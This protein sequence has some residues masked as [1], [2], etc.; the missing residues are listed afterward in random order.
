MKI[1]IVI[2]AFN[3]EKLLASTLQSLDSALASLQ[4]SGWETETI[5]CDNN[6]TDA[7]P[8]IARKHGAVVVFEPINQIARAR[9]IGA[10]AAT[11]EWL[12]FLDAD[13]RPSPALL[14]ATRAAI[15]SGRYIAGGTTIAFDES[16]FFANILTKIWNTLSRSRRL[17]AG[18]YIFCETTEFRKIGGFNE[19]L[20]AAEEIDLT[21]RLK[22]AGKKTGRKITILHKNPLLTSARKMNLY[23]RGDFFK[24]LLLACFRQKSTIRNRESCHVWYDGKR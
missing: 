24:F 12:L 2:P 10:R 7:T 6:S 11:G 5:V 23:S 8:S 21:K 22:S 15:Y 17:L 13:S 14:D 19:E 4:G 20:F 3:E 16:H 9:N 18:S 1:S